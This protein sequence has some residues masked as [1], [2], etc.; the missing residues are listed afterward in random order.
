MSATIS[1]KNLAMSFGAHHLFHDL[2]LTI[3][4]HATL[5]VV[6]RN[7][8]G[9]ST[10]LRAIA[11]IIP[12]ESGTITFAP[13]Q[14]SIGFLP[15]EA[16]RSEETLREFVRRRTGIGPAELE[17]E[18]TAESFLDDDGASYSLALDR[19]LGLGGGELENALPTVCARIGLDVEL[20]RPLG[21]LSGGQSARACLA[22]ILCSHF[23]VLL[24]DEPTNNLDADGLNLMS[25]FI[26]RQD[27]PVLIASHDRALLDNVATEILELDIVQQKVARFTGGWSD[28]VEA[29]ALA[30]SHE[31]EAYEKYQEKK[32]AFEAEEA[33]RKE[34]SNKA[35]KADKIRKEPSRAL[36]YAYTQRAEKQAGRGAR[37]RAGAERLE[38]VEA[39]RKEWQLRYSIDEA[40]P[41]AAAAL[42]LNEAVVRRGNFVLGPINLAVDAGDRIALIGPNGS[43][44]S[45]LLGAL[46]GW[47]PLDS[48][49]QSIGHRVHIGA[50]DQERSL[51]SGDEPL[52]ELVMRE[53]STAHSQLLGR[54][55]S[56]HNVA[57]VGTNDRA[58]ARTLLAKF[59]LGAE[60]IGRSCDSLSMGERTRA[61]MAIMQARPT[62][63]LVL[64]E[65]TNHLDVE[66]I[67]QLE[68]AIA[69]F[70]GTLILVTHDQQLLENVSVTKRWNLERAAPTGTDHLV[71]A[72]VGPRS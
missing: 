4:P 41:S 51:I 15:Q 50:I 25:E 9:K 60:H 56:F 31:W 28:Y 19:W 43:G 34:W 21:S 26:K 40:E 29:K 54:D 59:Q 35:L 30:R 27:S 8:A 61:A 12:P 67:E 38:V 68:R 72:R 5:G 17:M 13:A 49:R 58:A 10:L 42:T 70:H 52:I 24:L 22:S 47:L 66:A 64:D 39:P 36:Q 20:D 1:L 33:A 3:G 7:G 48:G 2:T 71:H 53:L 46:L 16:P 32:G 6:G 69:E 63:L 14:P 11:G 62:N 65:P 37:A 44:K 45:T 55:G 23:D 57:D 18:R